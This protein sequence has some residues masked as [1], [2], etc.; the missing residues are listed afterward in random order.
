MPANNYVQMMD[1]QN[2]RSFN[3][4]R[5]QVFFGLDAD[6]KAV[7]VNALVG[8]IDQLNAVEQHL[9]LGC[10]DA[11]PARKR[12]AHINRRIVELMAAIN[13]CDVRRGVL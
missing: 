4:A 1:D 2:Y 13:Q 8:M 3:M 7:M 9:A 6:A 12:L 5:K 11:N 10:G